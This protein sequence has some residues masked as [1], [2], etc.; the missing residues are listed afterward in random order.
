MAKI[1]PTRATHQGANGHRHDQS[2]PGDQ[3]DGRAANATEDRPL[4]ATHILGLFDV[5][6]AF[7]ILAQDRGI[8]EFDHLSLL[9]L[10]K[11]L[12]GCFGRGF[13]FESGH[14]QLNRIV[15]HFLSP[16]LF[17]STFL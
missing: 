16:H 10:L 2:R 7:F 11:L 13:I 6:L 15:A 17:C 12:Q 8:L 1:I 14:D 5:Q 3:A 4:T 9:G